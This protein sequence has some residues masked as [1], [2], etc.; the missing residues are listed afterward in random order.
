[1]SRLSADFVLEPLWHSLCSREQPLTRWIGLFQ[2]I[3]VGPP[4]RLDG[5]FICMPEHLRRT[6]ATSMIPV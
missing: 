3:T 1:M 5:Y 6:S 4:V 2:E